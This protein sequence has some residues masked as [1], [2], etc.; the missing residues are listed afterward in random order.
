MPLS[1]ITPSVKQLKRLK[2]FLYG[3]AGCGKTTAAISMPAPYIID[4]ERGTDHYAEAIAKQGGAVLQTTDINRVFDEVIAL[5]SEKHPYKTLVIDP[6][7]VIEST[8]VGGL[9]SKF[10]EN[11]MRV[12]LMRSNNMRRL[13]SLIVQ[14]DMNVVLIAHGKTQYGPNMTKTGTTFD[15][16]RNF[17]FMFDL[18]IELQTSRAGVRQANVVKS[19]LSGFENKSVFDW[20]IDAFRERLV[21]VDF[22][23]NVDPIV[24]ASDEEVDQLKSAI[25]SIAGN[26][27]A[28]V[29]LGIT[30][31]I[32][33]NPN[34]LD[35]TKEYAE[36]K[37]QEIKNIA[38]K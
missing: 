34:M 2:M 32:T 17:P 31:L 8:Y 18:V 36:R 35:I 3:D 13:Y 29:S 12:W 6:I 10:G 27:Q 37:I 33:S 11:D 25:K 23:G 24:Y 14:L 15:G 20:S 30:E 9:Q 16:W 26:K 19:R 38:G 28:M 1:G 22:E 4:A 7:S 5:S 21:G